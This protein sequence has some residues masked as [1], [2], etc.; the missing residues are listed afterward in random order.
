MQM[1]FQSHRDAFSGQQGLD[2]ARP[3]EKNITH[4]YLRMLKH[5]PTFVSHQWGDSPEA[6]TSLHLQAAVSFREGQ[7]MEGERIGSLHLR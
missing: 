1:Y 4:T 5:L 3:P 2:S 6:F 7:G